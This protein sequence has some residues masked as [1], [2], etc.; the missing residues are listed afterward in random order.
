M[1][2]GKTDAELDI[3]QKRLNRLYPDPQFTSEKGN[4]YSIVLFSISPNSHFLDFFDK[5]V[6]ID[7]QMEMQQSGPID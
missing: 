7:F 5:I 3:F 2:I 1:P 6:E 4:S